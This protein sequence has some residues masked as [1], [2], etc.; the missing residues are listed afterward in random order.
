MLTTNF[1]M[2]LHLIKML[3]KIMGILMST[4]EFM[5]T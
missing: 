1:I 2:T 5:A 3:S 4:S